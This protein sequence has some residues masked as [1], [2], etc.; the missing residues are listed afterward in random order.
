MRHYASR[1]TQQFF[2]LYYANI[3]S[4]KCSFWSNTRPFVLWRLK[5]VSFS[6]KEQNLTKEIELKKN[7]SKIY[8]SSTLN[9][10]NQIIIQHFNTKM[11]ILPWYYGNVTYVQVLYFMEDECCLSTC[12]TFMKNKSKNDWPIIW[13]CIH[14][15]SNNSYPLKILLKKGKRH[16]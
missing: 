9:P 4:N 3:L 11:L 1:S 14:F 12:M 15:T 13:I 6:F 16:G 10:W 7:C 8:Y 2:N 5:D